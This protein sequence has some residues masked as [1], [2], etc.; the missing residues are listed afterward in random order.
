MLTLFAKKINFKP[1]KFVK[2]IF[3]IDREAPFVEFD[4]AGAGP[5]AEEAGADGAGVAEGA[6]GAGFDT[7][8][9]CAG[10]GFDGD[11]VGY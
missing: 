6:V 7:D 10:A 5:V 8:Y 3:A 11:G 4:T 9:V 2:A 1:L